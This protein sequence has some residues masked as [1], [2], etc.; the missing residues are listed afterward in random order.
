MLMEAQ[1]V[2]VEVQARVAEVVVGRALDLLRQMRCEGG[3]A[4]VGT[5]R[6]GTLK[7]SM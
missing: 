2:V 5:G 1:P 7:R 3:R 6:T 4:E